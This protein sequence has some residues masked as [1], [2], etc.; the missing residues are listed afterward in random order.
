MW[1]SGSLG[2]SKR[3]GD[4]IIW[5]HF[6]EWSKVPK[7]TLD[8]LNRIFSIS[9]RFCMVTRWKNWSFGKSKTIIII[10]WIYLWEWSK[11]P[12]KTVN[13]LK[14]I[15]HGCTVEEWKFR[16][17]QKNH[18]PNLF[19]GMIKSNYENSRWVESDFY[20]HHQDF[21]WLHA[22]PINMSKRLEN[23]NWNRHT[24]QAIELDWIIENT[25]L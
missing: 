9:S 16:K 24:F 1:K 18:N 22:P 12:K 7:K 3:I 11:I 2:K 10:I 4:A 17:K 8:E 23:R 20:C 13:V 19:Y 25:I 14:R 21:A 15:L 5:I 6:T